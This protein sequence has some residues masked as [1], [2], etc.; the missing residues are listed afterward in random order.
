M[1]NILKLTLGLLLAISCDGIGD[2][3]QEIYNPLSECTMTERVQPGREVF[4]QWNGFEQDAQ[5][6]IKTSDGDEVA[7]EIVVVTSSGL[8]FKAPSN[9]PAGRYTVILKQGEISELGTIEILETTIPVTSIKVPAN[10]SPGETVFISGVGFDVSHTVVLK[11]SST[12]I[13]LDSQAGTSGINVRIPDNTPSGNY[14]VYLSDG[15]NEWLISDSFLVAV[16]KRLISVSR[17][18]PYDGDIKYVS[19][20]RI[21]Y[22]GDVH[23]A[24]VFTVELHENGEVLESL[25]YDR[26]AL[27]EDKV[28]RVDGG[29][30]SSNNFNFSYNRDS[31]GKILTA[32]VLRYSRTNPEG[33]MRE[34]TWIYDGNGIPSKVTYEL[35]DKTY[36]IQVYLF[37]EGNLVDTN[38]LTFVYDGSHTANPFAPDIAHVFDMMSNTMEPFL[39][40]PLLAGEEMFKSLQHPSAFERVTGATTTQKVQFTYVFDDDA[41]PVEMSWD[42]GM[43]HIAFEYENI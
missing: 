13:A 8:I 26:Y 24:I 20:Y 15:V 39:Y 16:K 29:Y 10:A 9:L 28:Y 38:A 21:E 32:D 35:N 25:Q 31:E 23:K 22:E 37:S 6:F 5:V 27:G 42:S 41:Y 7:V 11:S 17:V 30:S 18:D 33:S 3:G 4:I 34:F 12:D 2:Y 40:A 36:S 14:T 43:E 19:T 1:R